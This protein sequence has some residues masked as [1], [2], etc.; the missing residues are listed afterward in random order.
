[1]PSRKPGKVPTKRP[2]KPTTK[3]R[4]KPPKKPTL[5]RKPVPKKPPKKPPRK[6]PRK[7]SKPYTPP[8]GTVKVTNGRSRT[9]LLIDSAKD[10]AE[11]DRIK[12]ELAELKG[13]KRKPRKPPKKKR[14]KTAQEMIESAIEEGYR[15]TDITP[16]GT[17]YYRLIAELT[18]M[19]PHDIYTLFMS[20]SGYPGD[21]AA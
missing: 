9:T 10:K 16:E 19:S 20:P 6:P 18:D 12:A 7:P 4:P 17:E 13:K 2:R 14:R 5:T 8:P 3:A 21:Q 1:M 15:P 11:L